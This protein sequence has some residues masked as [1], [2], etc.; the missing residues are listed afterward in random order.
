[1]DYKEKIIK[2]TNDILNKKIS[3]VNGARKLS[4]FQFGYNL[5][6]NKNLLFFVGVNSETD[7]LPIGQEREKWN[8]TSLLKKDKETKKMKIITKKMHLKPVKV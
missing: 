8:S 2:I 3:I 6:N 7:H 4:Q 1:M 5:E